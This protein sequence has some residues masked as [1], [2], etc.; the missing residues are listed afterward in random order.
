MC[1][2]RAR[3]ASQAS[4]PLF[5]ARELIIETKKGFRHREGYLFDFLSGN[6]G[7]AFKGIKFI[8]SLDRPV[9]QIVNYALDLLF[10]A[11]VRQAKSTGFKKD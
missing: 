9:G 10:N 6:S 2:D 5:I 4:S 8:T 11:I 7:D 1:S 3:L